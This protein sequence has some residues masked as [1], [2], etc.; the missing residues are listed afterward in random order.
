MPYEVR[1]KDKAEKQLNKPPKND[2]TRIIGRML[3]FKENPLLYGAEKL[4]GVQGYRIRVGD[5]RI[6]YTIEKESKIVH[7][8]R[9]KHRRDVY[10]F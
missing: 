8:F 2:K 1:L 9:I 5:Y 7:V 3:S 6:L 10:R 4:Q